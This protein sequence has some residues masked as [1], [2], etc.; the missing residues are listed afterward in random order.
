[1][2]MKKSEIADKTNMDVKT[3]RKYMKAGKLPSQL[4]MDHNWRTRPDPFKAEWED[5][6][7]LLKNNSGL[8]A[9]TIFE[10]LQRKNPRKFQD[11]QLRTLQ[12]RI[13]FWR[14]TDGPAK[15]I[16]FEQEHKPGI[17]CASDFTDMNNLN[18][19]IC[20]QLF[21]HK[22][23]HF[24]LTYS[25][26][27]AGTV[28]F[29]ESFESLSTGLQNALWELGRVP[30]EHRTDRLSAAVNNLSAIDDFTPKYEQLLCHYNIKGQKTQPN[31]PHENGDIE[32]RHYRY[33]NAIDQAL[34]MRG[35]RDFDSRKDY[36]DFLQNKFNQL[37]SNRVEK[38]KDEMKILKELPGKKLEDFNDY[39]ATVSKFSTIRVS[40]NTYSVTSNLIGERIKARLH[41]E[42][43]DI[44][45]GAKFIESLPRL[46]GNGNHKIQ[47]R[48]VIDSLIRK[49]GA[50][51]NYK[52]KSDLFPTVHFRIAYDILKERSPGRANKEYLKILYI[53]AKKGEELANNALKKLIETDDFISSENVEEIVKEGDAYDI[54]SAVKIPKVDLKMYDELLSFGK[55]AAI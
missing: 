39:T 16:Y 37:N 6:T 46:I 33:K 51:E 17:L 20:G 36:E 8:Q 53:A 41:A 40:K 28:C 18:V 13:K 29:S 42:K 2:G 44:Y 27:E 26:W 24:V 19:T 12:R 9:K 1:M 35:S 7:D 47:Y 32:Q 30:R 21:K 15:E 3:A 22:L 54:P 45:Y 31:S 23:Y 10:D 49:P 43:I 38:L 5:I 55:E 52:Y 50:F 25:N 11:G 48:H 4:K 34:M 14:A